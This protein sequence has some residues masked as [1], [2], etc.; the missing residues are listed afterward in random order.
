MHLCTDQVAF[1]SK[2]KIV[3]VLEKLFNRTM[4]H[5]T[6]AVERGTS[7]PVFDTGPLHGLNHSGHNI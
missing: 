7:L 5:I 1:Y 4:A 6:A 2:Y 3:F